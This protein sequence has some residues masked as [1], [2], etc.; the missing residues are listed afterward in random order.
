VNARDA[1]PDGGML[2]ISVDEERLDA[3]HPSKLSPGSY[4]RLSVADTGVGM[5]DETLARAVEPFFSTK[6]I[7]KG[8]GLGLSMVHGLASQLGGGLRIQSQ[9]GVGTNVELW[10]PVSGTRAEART[11]TR[12]HEFAKSSGT[13]L[14]VDDEEAV[15]ASTA[16]MLSDLGYR[17]VEANSAEEALR[18]VR[19]GFTPDLLVTD[20]L[21]PGIT[22]TELVR[23]LRQQ[24]PS[25]PALL[26]S[27]YAEVED[28]APDLPRL[29]KP[30]RQAD[31]AASLAQLIDEGASSGSR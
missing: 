31:L 10:L 2:R 5:D 30:F 20:H 6:G 27:G 7:G 13:A 22:G 8:T 28:V 16:E 15:R 17:V 11:E 29:T 26:V 25:L 12:P 21:M 24:Q 18:A 1:M 9:V 4:V 14:L 23:Q 3:D 19:G